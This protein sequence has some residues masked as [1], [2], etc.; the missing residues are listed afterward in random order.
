MQDDNK[1]TSDDD[2]D[3]PVIFKKNQIDDLSQFNV[4]V[5]PVY[6]HRPEKRNRRTG[7]NQIS[8]NMR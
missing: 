3:I 6:C 4:S 8:D 7:K 1:Y 2:L 5:T